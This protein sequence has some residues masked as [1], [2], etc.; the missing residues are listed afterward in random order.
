MANVKKMTKADF[1]VWARYAI[2]LRDKA[3]RRELAFED[4][5]KRIR[6]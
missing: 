4:Y 1:E 2:E 6:E 5:V 3:E